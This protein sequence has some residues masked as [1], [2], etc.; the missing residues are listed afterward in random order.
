LAE[1]L[2]QALERQKGEAL[3]CVW[4]TLFKKKVGEKYKNKFS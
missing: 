3:P 1:E 4:M 2:I